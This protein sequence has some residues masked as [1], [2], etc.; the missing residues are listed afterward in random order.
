MGFLIVF[1]FW[2][3]VL[4][5]VVGRL[6]QHL[7]LIIWQGDGEMK[8]GGNWDSLLKKK[9]TLLTHIMINSI[10]VQLL[11]LDMAETKWF[12]YVISA[13][14][15]EMLTA[16]GSKLTLCMLRRGNLHSFSELLLRVRE[17]LAFLEWPL[18]TDT[19]PGTLYIFCLSK[20][21]MFYY[22][23][24]ASEGTKAQRG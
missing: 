22:T 4:I 3:S 8:S 6:I 12:L 7:Y 10:S 1:K 13:K 5:E 14:I 18:L 21:Q 24:S 11:S 19:K 20:T 23:F 15:R 16:W 9:K 2:M 17:A